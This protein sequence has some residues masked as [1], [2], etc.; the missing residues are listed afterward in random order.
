MA[1]DVTLAPLDLNLLSRL[2]DAAVADADP[3]EVM[4]PVDGPAG[5]TAERREAFTRFH[6][7]RSLSADPVERTWAITV[8]GAV[9]GAARLCPVP[10]RAGAVEAGVWIGRS[11]RGAGVGAAVFRELVA[12]ARAGGSGALLVSTTPGNTAV[13]RVLE[14]FGA[15][16]VREGDAVTAWVDLGG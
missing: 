4:P 16:P 15:D 3:E 14:A 9:V 7:S 5:W 2:L 11:H 12:L 10:G 1:I 8:D 13:L 6:R